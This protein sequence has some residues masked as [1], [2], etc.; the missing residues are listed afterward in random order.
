RFI[1]IAKNLSQLVN[2]AREKTSFLDM[3]IQNAVNSLTKLS[4]HRIERS[5][6]ILNALKEHAPSE[7]FP[8]LAKWISS[9]EI[10]I[11]SLGLSEETLLALAPELTHLDL[12]DDFT[13]T[14]E[15]IGELLKC[16]RSLKVLIIKNSNINKGFS[17]LENS[18]HLERLI[19]DNCPKFDCHLPS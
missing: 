11:K 13:Y 16:T 14:D 10:P 5:M 2:R 1:K 15:F 18:E 12:T 17:R 19:I 9:E 4:K 7:F 6:N 3:A 8:V